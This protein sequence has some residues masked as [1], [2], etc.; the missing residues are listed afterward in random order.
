MT[1][2]LK[3]Y[4]ITDNGDYEW[5]IDLSTGNEVSLQVICDALNARTQPVPVDTIAVPREVLQGVR[6]LI[7]MLHTGGAE[8]GTPYEDWARNLSGMMLTS[9]DAVLSEGK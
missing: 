2:E 1:E 3:R 9:L 8:E 7:D 5:V 4:A 6:G